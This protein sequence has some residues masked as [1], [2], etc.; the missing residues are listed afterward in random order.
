MW[1][2]QT[3][4]LLIFHCIFFAFTFSSFWAAVLKGLITYDLTPGNFLQ[5][6]E[7]PSIHPS[8]CWPL[9]GIPWL[10][11]GLSKAWLRHP[12]ACIKPAKAW[13]RPGPGLS[14]LGPGL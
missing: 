10:N 1:V 13:L 7:S 14:G 4:Y 5:V 9:L 11:P 3:T 6:S 2:N 8:I 12:M